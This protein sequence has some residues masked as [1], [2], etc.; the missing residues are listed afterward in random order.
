MSYKFNLYNLF[1]FN[2]NTN[3]I[4]QQIHEDKLKFLSKNTADINTLTAKLDDIAKVAYEDA[5]KEY[6]KRS[7]YKMLLTAFKE[8]Q[9][10]STLYL[11]RVVNNFNILVSD[12]ENAIKG[13]AALTGFNAINKISSVGVVTV[14]L[15]NFNEQ[16]TNLIIQN[17]A[18]LT[19]TNGNIRYFVHIDT[20]FI[21]LSLAKTKAMSL[22]VVQG[23]KQLITFT[24]TGKALQSY[25]INSNNI[26]SALIQVF[27]DN[28]EYSRVNKLSDML[29]NSNNYIL[30]NNTAGGVTIFFGNTANGNM[31]K[32]SSNISVYYVISDGYKGTSFAGD[33]FVFVN[34]VTDDNGNVIDTK[35]L[36]SVTA[37]N[38]FV[39]GYD[40]DSIDAIRLNAGLESTSNILTTVD[41]YFAFL[42]RYP[43]INVIDVWSEPAINTVNILVSPNIHQI[44]KNK[45]CTYFDLAYSD[46]EFD[47]EERDLLESNIISNKQYA[48]MSS[49][50]LYEYS[51]QAF[52]ILIFANVNDFAN[53]DNVYSKVVSSLHNALLAEYS[54]NAQHIKLANIA[55]ALYDDVQEFSKL[56]VQFVGDNKYINKFG[57]IDCTNVIIS[58]ESKDTVVLPYIAKGSY[59]NLDF[60]DMPFKILT[61]SADNQ[62]IEL[63]FANTY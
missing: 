19:N 33:N 14:S 16:T 43:H 31:P 13:L 6:S 52:G 4:K 21:Q 38:N 39:A 20:D 54:N 32:L 8:I 40:G 26:D 11:Y 63:K 7:P 22:N 55:K 5:N 51:L 56:K 59:D 35:Q 1:R 58:K 28:V 24:G 61:E 37:Q 12:N 47:S 17:G 3:S 9:N 36:L 53:V 50:K 10:L 2:R 42:R 46:F 45:L 57:D 44:C 41:N 29:F 62:W 48:L 30:K 18:Q 25:S 34:G 49:I 60:L 15:K 27:V 23:A